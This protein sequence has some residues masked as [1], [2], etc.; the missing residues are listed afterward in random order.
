MLLLAGPVSAQC[1]TGRSTSASAAAAFPDPAKVVGDFPDSAE[2]Y[3]A[4]RVLSS[5][6][7]A[8]KGPGTYE[9]ESAYMQ[10]MGAVESR[11]EAAGPDA[12]KAFST[13]SAQLIR[14]PVFKRRVLDRYHLPAVQAQQPQASGGSGNGCSTPAR[15][16]APEDLVQAT[17]SI[18]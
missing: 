3:A 14:D 18:G 11:A 10:Y 1:R 8:T 9:K 16:M 12:A 15:P 17:R 6:V 13:R 2:Q 4:L 7:N 5:A